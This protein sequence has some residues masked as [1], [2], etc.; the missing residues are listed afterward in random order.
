MHTLATMS[1]ALFAAFAATPGFAATAGNSLDAEVNGTRI[2]TE[3]TM[4]GDDADLV[5]RAYGEDQRNVVV[6]G[7]CPRGTKPRPVVFTRPGLNL[8]IPYCE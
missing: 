6:M 3:I 5:Y 1:L 8:A 7:T 2:A 4:V